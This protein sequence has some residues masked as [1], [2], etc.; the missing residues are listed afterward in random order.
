LPNVRA[1]VADVGHQLG[2]H[3]GD[4]LA[5]NE[6]VALEAARQVPAVLDRPSPVLSE[7]VGPAQ[8]RQMIGGCGAQGA[9]GQLA[10]VVVDGDDGVGALV[11]VDAQDDQGRISPSCGVG[12]ADRSAGI[13]QSGSDATLLSSHPGR[14]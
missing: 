13:S 5:G 7:L 4:A 1:G 3:P 11:R 10:A 2:R 12:S 14:S 8:Q 6:Q 9:A